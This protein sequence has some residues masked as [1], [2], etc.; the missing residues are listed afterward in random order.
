MSPR[1]ESLVANA[2]VYRH[3]LVDVR[4]LSRR[5]WIAN[6]ENPQPGL[7]EI[8]RR[9]FGVQRFIDQVVGNPWVAD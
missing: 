9:E 8:Y 3:S 6:I 4:H 2:R 5:Q 7:T 1:A